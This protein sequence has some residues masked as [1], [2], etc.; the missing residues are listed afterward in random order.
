M[1]EPRP[2][3]HNDSLD[4]LAYVGLVECHRVPRCL[5]NFLEPKLVILQSQ[6]KVSES[7]TWLICPFKRRSNPHFLELE[8]KRIQLLIRYDEVKCLF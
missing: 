2:A 1:S 5:L 4:G 6:L 7:R 8:A 3:A